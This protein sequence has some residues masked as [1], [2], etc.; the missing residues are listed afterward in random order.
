MN[1]RTKLVKVDLD[2]DVNASVARLEE[3]KRDRKVGDIPL[4]DE[5]WRALR[6]H[7]TAHQFRQNK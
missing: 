3:L 7:R 1:E 5:Y 2:N 4:K 6:K